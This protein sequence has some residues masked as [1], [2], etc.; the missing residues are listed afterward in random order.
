[1]QLRNLSLDSIAEAEKQEI[2]YYI[3]PGRPSKH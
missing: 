3:F 2:H 1:M